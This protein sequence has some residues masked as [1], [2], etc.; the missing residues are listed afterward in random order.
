MRSINLE[1]AVELVRQVEII[2]I[3][4]TLMPVVQDLTFLYFIL[5]EDLPQDGLE[6]VVEVLKDL[7]ALEA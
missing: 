6:E 1:A 5:L 2:M 7:V 3:P 4:Q